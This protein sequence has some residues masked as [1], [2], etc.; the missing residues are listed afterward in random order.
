MKKI[1]LFILFLTQTITAQTNKVNHWLHPDGKEVK[2]RV[3][4]NLVK[5]YPDNAMAFRKTIDSGMVYQFNSPKYSTYKV[6]YFI[7]KNEIE[8]ITNKTYSDATIFILNFNYLDDNCA[9]CFS[10]NMTPDLINVM[11]NYF[12]QHKNTIENNKN[13]KIISFYENG[14]SLHNDPESEE[15]YFYNDSHSFLRLNLFKNPTLCGSY[16]IIKPNG[17]TLIRNGEYDLIS[18]N[19]HLKPRIWNRFFKQ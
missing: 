11:K 5:K 3:I 6:D 4:M 15:E 17:Q 12:K 2:N 8:K 1:T 13:I 14:I 10:N 16:G 18:V 7:I 9:T 19:K